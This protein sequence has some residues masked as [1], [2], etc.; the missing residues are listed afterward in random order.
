MPDFDKP[1]K[2]Y[3][4]QLLILRDRYNLKIEND[5]LGIELL[6]T[7]SYYDLINGY[8]I[9]FM[10]AGKFKEGISILYLFRFYMF[11]K[12]MQSILF[13]YSVHVENIFKTK[14]AYF[15]SKKYGVDENKYLDILNFKDVR[16][17]KARKYKLKKLL[18]DVKKILNSDWTPT[19]TRYYKKKHN[20][21]P[22]W[23]LFKNISFNNAID[24]FS[25][26][27]T[28]DKNEIANEYFLGE[29]LTKEEKSNLLKM[30]LTI[31][32]KF[33][34]RI[35]HNLQAS[36]Y[37]FEQELL[38]KNLIKILP[39]G[40]LVKNDN[41]KNIGK[42]DLYAM[43]LSEFF[44]LNRNYLGLTLMNEIIFL[45]NTDASISETYK[46][47][48]DFPEDIEDR[49]KKVLETLSSTAEDKMQSTN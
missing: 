17:N 5:Q 30:M 21:V 47:I 4:E 27:E 37:K 39:V 20:H 33:R 1:F 36:S 45:L 6:K 24:L 46:E 38:H 32:R 14:L 10:E 9:F 34:N 25:F 11:D 16:K 40:L 12:N 31:I 48:V 8:Q 22:P 29:S 13:K 42:N 28:E 44:L 43:I 18:D 23:I 26:L 7:I 49:L 15:I 3:E 41:K 35:A 2:T 19:P